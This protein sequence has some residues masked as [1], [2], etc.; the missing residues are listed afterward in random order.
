MAE[1]Y[2]DH[3]ALAL[4]HVS[5]ELGCH[6]ARCYCDVSAAAFRDWLR[7]AVRRR[8]RRGSTT[9]GGR[10]SG[11][12]ATTTSSEVLPPRSAPA[13]ANPTQ[14]LD[15]LRFSSDQLLDNF[16]AERDVLH[17]VS[18][19]VP[20]TTNFMVMRQTFEMDYLRWGREVDVV[21]NDHYL[22]AADADGAPRA[23]LQRRPHP[24]HRRR[25]ARGC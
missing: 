7:G 18:P 5:N 19:G 21:S 1:R 8:R 6:N 11:P 12:S 10:R 17:E 4:W 22:I 15:F 3:P 23:G 24:R 20:V 13:F 25:R 9:P 16:V 14:Q 2:G